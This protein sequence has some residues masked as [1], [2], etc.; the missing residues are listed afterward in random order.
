M[1]ETVNFI[2]RTAILLALALLFQSL[3]LFMPIPSLVDQYVVGSLV[4]LCLIIAAVIVGI[5]GGLIVAI[6][7]PVIAFLQN[8]LLNPVMVPFVALG[9]ATIVVLVALIYRK[10]KYVALAAGALCKFLVLYITVVHVAIP[11]FMP[12][13]SPQA[14]ELMSLKFSWPQLITASVGGMLALMVLPVLERA[15]KRS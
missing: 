10:N 15:L 12:N 8:V 11:L 13:T 3:R 7:T 4:N 2:G 6:L 5:E 14:K 9:N 1:N